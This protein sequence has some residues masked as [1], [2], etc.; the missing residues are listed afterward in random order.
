MAS[1]GCATG[2]GVQCAVGPPAPLLMRS[3]PWRL[4]RRSHLQLVSVAQ[5]TA[6]MNFYSASAA[7]HQVH[8]L[9]AS[10]SWYCAVQW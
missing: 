9:E 6:A 5:I 3:C 8:A 10:D 2:F 7:T 4:Q 1:A